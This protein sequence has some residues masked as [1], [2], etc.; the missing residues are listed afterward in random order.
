MKLTKKLKKKLKKAGI[1]L[2]FEEEI[3]FK[4]IVKLLKK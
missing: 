4:K 2:T 1:T 3:D